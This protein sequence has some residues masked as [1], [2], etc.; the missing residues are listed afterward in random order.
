[1]IK[2]VIEKKDIDNIMREEDTSSSSNN[3]VISSKASSS[4]SYQHFSGEGGM[5]DDELIEKFQK[6]IK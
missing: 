3:N 4:S 2:P 5:E 6:V 1:M